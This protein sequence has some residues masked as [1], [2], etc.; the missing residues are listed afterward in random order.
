MRRLL[1]IG[2]VLHLY[3]GSALAKGPVT[4]AIPAR[5]LAIEKKFDLVF[6]Q[7]Y[8]N[9]T[10][11]TH[12]KYQCWVFTTQIAHNFLKTVAF[13]VPAYATDETMEKCLTSALYC[14]GWHQGWMELQ[15]ERGKNVTDP[16]PPGPVAHTDHT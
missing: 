6:Y 7:T 10:M 16:V 11:L 1:W 5:A 2:I 15:I 9:E 12:I 3:I 14:A 8:E 4:V 13:S